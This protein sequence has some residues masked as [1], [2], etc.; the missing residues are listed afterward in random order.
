VIWS[1]YYNNGGLS[2]EADKWVS[3]LVQEAGYFSSPNVGTMAWSIPG[4][5]MVL[6]SHRQP[7]TA[8]PNISKYQSPV[9]ATRN[10]TLPTR[11]K[12]K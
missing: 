12:L 7:K 6:R 2:R 4:E 1:E 10:M 8:A 3:C 11:G 9:A 5:L